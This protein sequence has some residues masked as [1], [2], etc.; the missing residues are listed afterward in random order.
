MADDEEAVV[1]ACKSLICCALDL[2]QSQEQLREKVR[3][4][5]PPSSRCGDAAEHVSCESRLS[6]RACAACRTRRD[7]RVAPCC[8]T[9]A[10]QH[11]TT[12]ACTKMH[13]LDSVSCRVVTWRNKWNL[14]FNNLG[15]NEGAE[16][17]L[18]LKM[19]AF[20]Y[21]GCRELRT[22]TYRV[23]QQSKPVPNY[24]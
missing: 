1:L 17:W 6:L 22:A 2:H 15:D 23:V 16:R 24:Q 14:G 3:W 5:C 21:D 12:F 7:E 4:T 20:S 13:E 10:T 8:R 19:L 11:V 18:M 9:S